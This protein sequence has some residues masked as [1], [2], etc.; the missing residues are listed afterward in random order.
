MIP[1]TNTITQVDEL[2]FIEEIEFKIGDP[3]FVMMT[4]ARLYSDVTTAIIR[5]YSTNAYDA[6]VMA[7]HTDPIEVTLP[8]MMNPEFI[9][10]DHGVGMDLEDFR[11]IYTQFGISNKRLRRDTNGQLGYG[12]KSGVAYTTSFQVTSVKD[13]I[14]NVGVIQRK[15]DWTIVLKVLATEKTNEPNGTEIRI[16]VHNWQEFV[17]KAN[18]FYKYWLPGR[19]LVNGVAPS[20]FAKRKI[21]DNLYYSEQW[22]TSYVV[23]GNV[24]YRI[25]NPE[26]LFRNSKMSR[27]NFIAYV[28]D[29]KTDDGAAPVEFTPSRE[30]LEYT[31]RTKAT[32]QKVVDDFEANIIKVAQKEIDAATSHFEA[33]SKWSEWTSRLGR[34]LFAELEYDG[35]KFESDFAIN[36]ARY[37]VSQYRGNTWRVNSWEVAHM[38][39]TLVVT[40]FMVDASS[41][42]KAKAK[43]YAALMGY[44]CSYVLFTAQKAKDINSPWISKKQFVTWENLKAALPK[45][46]RTAGGGTNWNSG[47]IPG[48]FDYYTATSY[49]T[50]K[51]VPAKAY[52]A[53]NLFYISVKDSKKIKVRNVI[54]LLGQGDAVVIVLSANRINKFKRDYPG[55]TDF[56]AHVR[57]LVVKDGASLLSQQAKDALDISSDVENWLDRLPVNELDDPEWARLAGLRKN[58]KSLTKRY[59]D[60][61]TLASE[62]GMGYNGV[63][64]YESK[65]KSFG[66][67][68]K[69][70]LLKEFSY[71][72]RPTPATIKELVLYMNAKHAAAAAV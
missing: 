11:E 31:E 22:N 19:V 58:A 43:E 44:P 51:T 56:Y 2:P 52:N 29:F 32:L 7:G 53:N 54:S 12:S 72:S 17:H 1:V 67:L 68:T 36:A 34:G 33:Y 9:V 61:M 42:A 26:A 6:H 38:D 14:K 70:P 46:V 5:E 65:D 21:I 27:I 4:Q 63:A 3:R 18:E 59:E 24:A 39:R 13:G 20:P 8:S 55:V 48:S 41:N 71:Y 37:Q 16:P 45:K 69:Y 28:D 25:N 50:E 40:E 30:D 10:R 15:P 49:E 35:D 23:L 62:V 57:G 64:R 60:N 47:R 66:L